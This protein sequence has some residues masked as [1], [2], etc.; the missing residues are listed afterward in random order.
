MTTE[1]S[2]I[3]RYVFLIL[4]SHVFRSCNTEATPQD[5]G[6]F[7][8]SIP[9][10][11]NDRRSGASFAPLPHDL[12]Q[13]PAA[14]PRSAHY[15]S[16]SSR[17]TGDSF[18]GQNPKFNDIVKNLTQLA[19][20]WI[21]LAEY[22]RRMTHSR[23][24]PAA[25]AFLSVVTLAR[26]A[27]ADPPPSAEP[28]PSSSA[29]APPA[30]PQDSSSMPPVSDIIPPPVQ[31]PAAPPSSKGMPRLHIEADR[32][33]V[34]LLRIERAMSDDMGEGILVRNVCTAPCDQVI[35]AKKGQTFFFGADGM[36]PSRGF[37]LSRL[38]GN[39][40]ARVDGGSLVG[41]Q[42]GY[43]FGG[44]GGAAMIGGAAMLA[45]GYGGSGTRLNAEGKVEEGANSNL[46]TG[47]AITLGVGTALV[48]TAVVLVVTAKTKITLL[49]D[50]NKSARVTL[51]MGTLRF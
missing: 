48:V 45:A 38:E 35:D 1:S 13:R 51:E 47:G 31:P 25:F 20:A 15:F 2:S 42:L 26:G 17:K 34:R 39:L 41:R 16:R 9:S 37:K 3:V 7:G 23:G 30:T 6:F 14:D 24:L 32:P 46:T 50:E 29:T 12:H 18:I 19:L 4:Q 44:F 21:P 5:L 10:R 27:F 28:P 49:Q 8:N 43:L 40:V 11:P 33:G 36:V 22:A